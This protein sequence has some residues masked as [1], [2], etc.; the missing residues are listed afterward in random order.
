MPAVG[1]VFHGAE[2]GRG[3][4]R[5][6]RRPLA[7]AGPA[8]SDTRAHSLRSGAWRASGWRCRD[9]KNVGDLELMQVFLCEKAQ[10]IIFKVRTVVSLAWDNIFVIRILF[11]RYLVA[12]CLF[13]GF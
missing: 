9:E 2:G 12:I 13:E 4:A 5:P 11:T 6:E 1:L 3:A 7:A 8:N 10:E